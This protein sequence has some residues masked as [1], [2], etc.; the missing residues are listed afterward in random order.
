[1]FSSQLGD[2]ETVIAQHDGPV[3]LSGDFNTW[4][5]ERLSFLKNMI[6]RLRLEEVIFSEEDTKA[7]IRFPL[8]DPLDHIF[9]RDLKVR[10][11]SPDVLETIRSSDHVPMIVEFYLPEYPSPELSPANF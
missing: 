8:S 1:M 11:H 10:E 6:T 2:I 4:N 3:I 7:L 9:F 5:K